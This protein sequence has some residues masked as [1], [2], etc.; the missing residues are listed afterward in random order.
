MSQ[1][2]DWGTAKTWLETMQSMSKAVGFLWADILAHFD[3]GRCSVHWRSIRSIAHYCRI[4]HGQ[5]PHASAG[6]NIQC[7]CVCACFF[8]VCIS[9]KSLR[10]SC[11]HV[12]T[13]YS[14]EFP[15]D[16][17]RHPWWY[18]KSWISEG[19]KALWR[20]P[21]RK[22]NQRNQLFRWS[23]E[24]CAL[25]QS[26][27][28]SCCSTTPPVTVPISPISCSTLYCNTLQILAEVVDTLLQ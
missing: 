21:E 5:L 17:N 2:G 16:H 20:L 9:D 1:W 24:S 25:P 7:Q 13:F 12:G 10:R 14:F 27:S 15:W 3:V 22:Q 8:R 23:H 19:T 4:L 26:P 18:W 6:I 28:S 11:T